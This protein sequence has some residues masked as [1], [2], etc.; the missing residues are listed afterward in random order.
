MAAAKAI[1]KKCTEQG[2]DIKEALDNFNN[3]PRRKC[4]FSPLALFLLR[5]VK[6]DLSNSFTQK[7]DYET[8]KKERLAFIAKNIKND[9]KNKK[10]VDESK[11]AEGENVRLQNPETKVWNR[12]GVI[13]KVIDNEKREILLEDGSSLVRNTKFIKHEIADTAGLNLPNVD[14]AVENPRSQR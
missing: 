7:F 8:A 1:I 14:R 2:S 6:N 12:S 10:Q 3:F 9:V 4:Q 13:A 5:P 11:F